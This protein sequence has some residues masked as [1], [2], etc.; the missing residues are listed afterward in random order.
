MADRKRCEPSGCM[1]SGARTTSLAREPL[2]ALASSLI[3]LSP[4][5][6]WMKVISMPP[7][8]LPQAAITVTDVVFKGGPQGR[9]VEVP[10]RLDRHL[11]VAHALAHLGVKHIDMPLTPDRVWRE[12]QQAQE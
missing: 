3:A 7:N 2:M 11:M 5:R 10:K 4:S 9:A 8:R 1:K 12:T 6:G